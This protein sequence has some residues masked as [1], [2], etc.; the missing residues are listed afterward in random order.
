M[1]ASFGRG[2][3]SAPWPQQSDCS[4]PSNIQDEDIDQTT[5]SVPPS[6]SLIEFTGTS[7]LIAANETF[8]LR[9][10]LNSMLN[11]IR[12]NVTFEDAKRYTDEIEAQIQALPQWIGATSEAPQA[13]LSIT[14]RQYLLVLHDRQFRL[15]SSHSERNFSKLILADTAAKII[16]SHK[17]LVEKGN[18]ALQFLCHD[19]LRA[20]LSVCHIASLSDPQSDGMLSDLVEKRSTAVIS[21][22]IDLLA[23]KIAR[24]GREQR[25]LWIVLA[26]NAFMKSRQ[27]PSQKIN[28]MQEAVDKITRPYYKILACQEDAPSA[29]STGPPTGR[30]E[31]PNGILEYLPNGSSTKTGEFGQTDP[32]LLDLEDIAAWTFDD[33][34]FVPGM[35]MQQFNEVY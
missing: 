19:Q 12:Q 32:T 11:N 28:N 7:Y 4:P 14:L 22:T 27:D 34:A 8:N 31:L 35:E 13:L 23:D 16:D 21:D 29:V 26:A 25:Q 6:R 15:A 18:R 10:M 5:E 2:M 33:W 17:L 20:A 3:I 24:Y 1:Q 9:Y 30:E